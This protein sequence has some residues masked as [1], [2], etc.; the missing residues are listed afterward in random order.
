MNKYLGIALWIAAT[1]VWMVGFWAHTE[2]M[3]KMRDAGYRY[4]AINPLA[5]LYVFRTREFIIFVVSGIVFGA[6]ILAAIAL[7]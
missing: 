2:M 3:K 6:I 5:M 4:W 1:A 7:S